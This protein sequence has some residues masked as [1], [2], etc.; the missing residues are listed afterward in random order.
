MQKPVP[1]KRATVFNFKYYKIFMFKPLYQ[2]SYFIEINLVDIPPLINC[3]STFHPTQ[4]FV[5]ILFTNH[6]NATT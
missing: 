3:I 1:W 4:M 2:L 6:I 5:S